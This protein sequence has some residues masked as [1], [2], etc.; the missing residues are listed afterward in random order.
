MVMVLGVLAYVVIG[1]L[2]ASVALKEPEGA[3]GLLIMLIW[4]ILL[5]FAIMFA[6]LYPL[7]KLYEALFSVVHK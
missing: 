1:F 3:S 2:F 5:G 4:P 6:V 7:M